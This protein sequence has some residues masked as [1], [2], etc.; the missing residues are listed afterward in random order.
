MPPLTI[1][2]WGVAASGLFCL[3]MLIIIV[4][5]TLAFGQ[6]PIYAREAGSSLAGIVYAFGL[7]MLPWEKESAAKHLWTYI[8]GILYHLGI[9]TAVLFLATLVLSLS[10]SQPLLQPTRILLIVGLVSGVALLLKRMLKPQMRS[11]SSADD[12]VSNILV[13][14]LLL[15]ALA[16]TWAEAAVVALLAIAMIVFV[17]I[18]F[19]KLRHCA[20]FFY[21]RILFGTFFGRRGVLPHP[22]KEA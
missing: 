1:L 21:S 20:F 4:A 7:G 12:Y 9:L 5:R 2:K 17:Y 15:S 8:G 10:L 18:P 3:V 19:G 11:L 22:S 16:A 13:D 6:R 14:L